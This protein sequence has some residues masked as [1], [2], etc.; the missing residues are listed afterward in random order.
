MP[1]Y[2]ITKNQKPVWSKKAITYPDV[3]EIVI[4]ET[5]ANLNV[6][7]DEGEKVIRVKIIKY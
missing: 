3:R 7:L 6:G 4:S 2:C 1:Y 5:K